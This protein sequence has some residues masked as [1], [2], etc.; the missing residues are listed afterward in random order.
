MSKF[1]IK[2]KFEYT[3]PEKPKELNSIEFKILDRIYKAVNSESRHS[4][5]FTS[6][7]LYKEICGKHIKESGVDS[8]YIKITSKETGK[9]VYRRWY[10]ITTDYLGYGVKTKDILYLDNDAKTILQKNRN[11]EDMVELVLS[12]SN[13][14]EFYWHSRNTLDRISFRINLISFI[15]GLSIIELIKFIF[16][17][18]F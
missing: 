3:N 17:C 16:Q 6:T 4:D 12:K 15:L 18:V 2:T 1:Y 11:S 10:G 9:K 5:V 8:R 13:A 7:N 14:F